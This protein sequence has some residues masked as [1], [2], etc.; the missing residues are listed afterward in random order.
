MIVFENDG[1]ID[2][3][4]IKT[5]GVNSKNNKD[6]AIGYFGTGLKYAVAILLRT[7]HGV[8]IITGTNTY[9][10]S[11]A[12]S[13]IR[14]DDFDIVTMNG[15]ELGYTTELGKDWELWMAFRELMSNCLDEGGRTYSGLVAEVDPD[16]TYVIVT[17][18]DF[19][20]CFS[21]R[22]NY[23]LNQDIYSPI[24]AHEQVSV[25]EKTHRAMAGHV[26]LKG[27]RVM[28]TRDAALFDYNHHRGLV[29]TE[30]R[31]IK[32]TWSTLYHVG[33]AVTGSTDK[34]FI[35]RMVTAEP[36][37]YE[38]RINYSLNT[39]RNCGFFL[40]TVGILRKK[41]KD[42]GIN[43]TAIALHKKERKVSTVLPGISCHLNSVQQQQL[44]KAIAFCKGTLELDIDDFR[45][46][47]CK[48]LGSDGNLGRADMDEG[49]MYIS[50]KCFS[51][52]TKR[53]AVS[54]L[55]EYTHCKHEVADETLAQKWIYLEQIM[56]LGERINGE[57]L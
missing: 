49:I 18:K 28:Q 7:G 45:L 54:I 32:D 6:T 37:T 25:Y 51:Q 36:G 30:D 10:F 48:D 29:L 41:Y 20:K 8:S 27:V 19:G 46:I 44:D 23:F 31:T 33:Q 16:K 40:D 42:Q 2:I 5:F 53:V 47:V 24:V 12:T 11:I 52:G 26:F 39:A 43:E 3:R 4:A 35:R 22:D 38:S 50:K 34:K 56:S 57:P 55:E 21:E 14:N 13:R 15:E 17:G 1:V 9:K